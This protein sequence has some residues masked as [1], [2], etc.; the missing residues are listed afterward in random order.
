MTDM[1]IHGNGPIVVVSVLSDDA[2]I[3]IPMIYTCDRRKRMM[4]CYACQLA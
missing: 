2:L 1:A 4:M 3:I